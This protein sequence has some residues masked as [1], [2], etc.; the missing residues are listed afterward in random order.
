MADLVTKYNLGGLKAS[1]SKGNGGFCLHNDNDLLYYLPR[2]SN[3]F[4]SFLPEKHIGKMINVTWFNPFTGK[5]SEST[6]QKISSKH[7]KFY[8]PDNKGFWILIVD[9]DV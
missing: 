2:E 4:T 5:Y 1:D 6:I 8:K 3:S 9:I 7:T